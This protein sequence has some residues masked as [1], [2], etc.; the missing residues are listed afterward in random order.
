MN[1][2]VQVLWA[3]ETEHPNQTLVFTKTAGRQPGAGHCYRKSSRDGMP[4]TPKTLHWVACDQSL[5]WVGQTQWGS[6]ENKIISFSLHES[7]LVGHAWDKL[8]LSIF[9]YFRYF[10]SY[11]LCTFSK[12]HNSRQLCLPENNKR[13]L[14]CKVFWSEKILSMRLQISTRLSF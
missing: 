14:T 5:I 10:R 12:T 3:H 9:K 4:Y 11:W 7:L 6:I 13:C 1:C 8:I 2:W